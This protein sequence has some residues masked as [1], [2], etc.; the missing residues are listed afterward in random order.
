M[1]WTIRPLR[2][3]ANFRGRSRRIELWMFVLFLFVASI[4]AV[5]LDTL[6]GTGGETVATTVTGPGLWSHDVVSQGGW[7]TALFGFAMLVPLIAA[8][9]RR[10]HDSG[11][12]GWWLL[13]ALV[14]LLGGLFLLVL[15]L[16]DSQRGPNRYG[17]DPRDGSV[18]G[19]S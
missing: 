8:M 18:P 7:I 3:Y 10:L 13:A 17:P 16:T 9:V 5:G 19:V 12:R 2:R 6:L 14:P 11:W 15:F 1:H 4:A